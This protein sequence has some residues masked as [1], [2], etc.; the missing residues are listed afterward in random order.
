MIKEFYDEEE[1]NSLRNGS[2]KSKSHFS[3]SKSGKA[4][5]KANRNSGVEE[6]RKSPLTLEDK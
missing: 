1:Q 2:G 3:I 5:S 6:N 4:Q